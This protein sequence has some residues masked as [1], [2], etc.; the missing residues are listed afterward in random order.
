MVHRWIAIT[1]CIAASMGLLA[2]GPVTSAGEVGAEPVA[3]FVATSAEATAGAGAT[4]VWAGLAI[5]AA[6]T[7]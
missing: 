5:E 3:L 6:V 2:F 4:A 1:A 7:H